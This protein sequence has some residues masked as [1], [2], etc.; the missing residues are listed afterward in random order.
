ETGGVCDSA[1][2]HAVTHATL[3]LADITDDGH[4]LC[5]RTTAVEH[6]ARDPNRPVLRTSAYLPYRFIAVDSHVVC[7]AEA[8]AVDFWPPVDAAPTET[9]MV[10]T[11]SCATD[12]CGG[13]T[14]KCCDLQPERLTPLT[15]TQLSI[16]VKSVSE[17]VNGVDGK[18]IACADLDSNG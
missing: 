13:A 9:V 10:E 2:E 1:P 3:Q 7:G 4:A 16:P 6:S 17:D 12:G 18:T 11:F 5:T 14:S 8:V 15:S